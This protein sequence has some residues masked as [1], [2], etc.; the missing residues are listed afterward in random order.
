M[1]KKPPK[2]RF[3]DEISIQLRRLLE[4]RCKIEKQ[5]EEAHR[6]QIG[7][8]NEQIEVLKQWAEDK[9]KHDS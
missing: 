2:K 8:L 5:I 6:R 3:R 9:R 1:N 4:E 7:T